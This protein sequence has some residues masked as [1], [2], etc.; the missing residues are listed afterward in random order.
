MKKEETVL[1]SLCAIL[2]KHHVLPAKEQAAI[3]KG[4][5]DSTA[6]YFEEFLIDEGLVDDVNVIRALGEYYQVPAVDVVGSLFEHS[7]LHMFPKDFLLRKAIIPL[8]VEE[9]IMIMI[10]ADPKDSE[11]LPRIGEYVSYDVRFQVG[12]RRHICDAV[13]EFYDKSLTE[14][15]AEQDM[16]TLWREQHETA[17]IKRDEV[18]DIR[19]LDASIYD[20]GD[21]EE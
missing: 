16:Q 6:E 10:A 1:E 18:I 8:M 20:D 2:I 12:L 5:K 19:E 13:K 14:V 11:L 17:R 15:P 4:F 9:D 3:V 7:L 21:V